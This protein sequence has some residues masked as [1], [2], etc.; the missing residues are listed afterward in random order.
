MNSSRPNQVHLPL[1]AVE[2]NLEPALALCAC[3]SPELQLLPSRRLGFEGSASEL[4]ATRNNNLGAQTSWF[5]G[6]QKL[7]L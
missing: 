2:L 7:K 3:V 6:K 4:R 5:A 1:D